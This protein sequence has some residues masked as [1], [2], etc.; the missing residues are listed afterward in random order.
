MKWIFLKFIGPL[1]PCFHILLGKTYKGLYT[2][3]YRSTPLS[4]GH[5][6]F[7]YRY[8][9]YTPLANSYRNQV[10]IEFREPATALSPLAD[11]KYTMT[12]SDDTGDLF[13]VIATDYAE[14]RINPTRDEV[15]LEWTVIKDTP[16]LYGEVLIDGEGIAVGNAEIRDTIFK[17]EMPIALQTI[18]H[19]DG[20]LFNANPELRET[21]IFIHFT[22]SQAL[23]NKLYNFG[24]IG[25]YDQLDPN[26]TV[27]YIR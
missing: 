16:V 25:E 18:Y 23:Y 22:S 8:S 20:Q 10:Y 13:V 5:L 12:H 9:P 4:T 3:K 15:R 17:R 27:P 11:R 24:T 7:P 1:I 6:N 21:P 2:M 26:R 19:A 14:D